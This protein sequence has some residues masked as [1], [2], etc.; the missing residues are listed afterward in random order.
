[1]P[2]EDTI[3]RFESLLSEYLDGDLSREEALEFVALLKAEPSFTEGLL[4]QLAMDSRLAQ[5]ESEAQ[6]VESFLRRVTATLAAGADG[7]QFI[8]RVMNRTGENTPPGSRRSRFWLLATAGA[9]LLVLGLLLGSLFQTLPEKDGAV[10]YPVDEGVAVL[11]HADAV[12][13]LAARVKGVENRGQ[14]A[15]APGLGHEDL[16]LFDQAA[17]GAGRESPGMWQDRRQAETDVALALAHRRSERTQDCVG[18][19]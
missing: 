8:G 11:V 17:V 16:G 19:R 10:T 15:V 9:A 1:M 4:E 13:A 14:A 6:D 5:F 2:D 3:K 7:E 12:H 18:I